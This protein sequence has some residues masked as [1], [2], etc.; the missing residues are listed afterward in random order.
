MRIG[1]FGGSFDPVHIGHISLA[2][3]CWHELALDKVLLVPAN[4]SPFKFCK[5]ASSPS[6]RLNMLRLA[7]SNDGR[8]GISTVE[9]DRGGVSYTVDTLVELKKE[10]GSKAEFF[11][12]MGADSA[13]GVSSWKDFERIKEMA[14][15]VAVSRV[16]F[17]KNK[18]IDANFKFVEM[19]LMNISSTM[20]RDRVATKRPVEGFVSPLVAGYIRN[21]GLYRGMN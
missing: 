9:L 1:I 21:K 4:I 17:K 5:I 19:P 11:L 20:I 13:G 16:S 18:F 6:D 14:S 12:L 3:E 7:I 10:Y 8:F 15:L 2:L